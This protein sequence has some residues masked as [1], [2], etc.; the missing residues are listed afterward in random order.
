MLPDAN[1]RARQH[2]VPAE[3][4]QSFKLGSL[5]R[6]CMYLPPHFEETRLKELHRIIAEHPLGI[7]VFNGPEG[8]EASHLPF[9]LDAEAGEHGRLLAHV[10]RANSLW[11]QVE[12]GE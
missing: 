1:L 11:R 3:S 12:E 10:A 6:P 2:K 4:R 7:L 9:E 5:G 8:L